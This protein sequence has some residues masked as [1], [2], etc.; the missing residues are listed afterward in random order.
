VV[1]ASIR[2]TIPSD[3]RIEARNILISVAERTRIE[4]GCISCE[5]YQGVE[6]KHVILIDELWWSRADLERHLRSED[7]LR[8]LLVVEMAAEKPEIRFDTITG[9]TGVDLIE[10]AR[11]TPPCISNHP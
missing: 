11:K 6:N 5:V 3:K 4:P 10:K 7:Y 9:S 2:M 1:R 8:V